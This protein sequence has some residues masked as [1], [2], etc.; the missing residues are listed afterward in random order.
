[1]TSTDNALPDGYVLNEYRLESVLGVGGF[2]VTYLAIDRHLNRKVALKEYLPVDFAAR[3]PDHSISART[4]ADADSFDWG[5]RRFLDEARTLASFRHPNIVRVMRFFEGNNTGYM[6]M[7]FVEGE[8]LNSWIA[9]RRPLQ[10]QDLLDITG[11]LLDGLSVMH[12]ASYLHRDI[13]PANIFI[14]ADGSPVL[15]DFGSARSV[16]GDRGLTAMVS[17][18]YAPLEQYHAHGKQ[19]PWSDLYALGGVMYW[20]VTGSKPIEAA[21]RVRN[22]IMTPASAHLSTGLYTANILS[23]IDWALRPN[24]DERPQSA[25]EFLARLGLA[26]Q[27]PDWRRPQTQRTV[28]YAQEHAATQTFASGMTT[29]A[30]TGSFEPDLIKRIEME[31]ARVLGPIAPVIVRKAARKATTLAELCKSVAQ[32]FEDE[33]TRA[34]FLRKFAND[35]RTAPPT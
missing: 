1:M 33:T 7:E 19:G 16:S 25:A 15:I 35:G 31:A 14:R 10:Q 34:A 2:G 26:V 6:V 8:S 20:M 24:E 3:G 23:A 29:T 5:L 22:D 27:N 21:A 28:P 30:M 13:K 32:E 18:G 4:D 11:S 9:K 12:S 17:P